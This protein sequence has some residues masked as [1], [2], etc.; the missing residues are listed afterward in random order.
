MTKLQHINN[1][2]TDSSKLTF[3]T[4]S[5]TS[6]NELG[7]ITYH[8][9]VNIRQ[10]SFYEPCIMLIISGCK[11]I[12]DKERSYNITAGSIISVPGHSS[13]SFENIPDDKNI[14]RSLLIPFE[15]KVIEL[16]NNAYIKNNTTSNIKRK[17]HV[18]SC[19]EN[20]EQSIVH[21][22]NYTNNSQVKTHR[23][24]EILLNLCIQN[25]ALLS[26]SQTEILWHDNVRAILRNDLS[27]QWGIQDICKLLF[28]SES[29][30][31]RH[32]TSENTSF[33]EIILD[34]RLSSSFML[35]LKTNNPV[36]HIASACGYQSVSRFTSNFKR[37]FGLTPTD[38]RKTMTV[39]GQH[40]TDNER[41]SMV[42]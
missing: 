29:T 14:F 3:G 41:Y 18:F 17:L 24:I 10:V 20:T 25:Q 22:L 28:I 1:F 9:P 15:S 33:R 34:L 30:L 11:R 7:F 19:D 21:F 12:Y 27:H 40:L 5:A 16:I 35:L 37:K 42:Y 38:L 4:S 26:Y 6:L 39:S 36:Y 8:Q 32:L 13:Y 31:R 23:L 2:I